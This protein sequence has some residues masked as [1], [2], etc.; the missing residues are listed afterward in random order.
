[1]TASKR[2]SFESPSSTNRS[3][4][5]ECRGSAT[6]RPSG[7]PKT[8]A[9]PRHSSEE[10]RGSATIRP[11]GSPKT[12]AASSNETRC[13]ARFVA[14]FCGYH[15]NSNA[16][17]HY[18]CASKV[19]ATACYPDI[20]VAS[21]ALGVLFVCVTAAASA[22]SSVLLDTMSEELNRN[23]STLKTKADPAP[24]FLSYEVTE[25]DFHGV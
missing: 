2:R 25:E 8:V 22:Q 15:P 24:Y 17:L 19:P 4:S 13:L 21:P 6:I 9:D 16:H 11:S 12:V 20:L 1:M 10:E 18:T 3:S 7:S 14:A 5:E 23:F